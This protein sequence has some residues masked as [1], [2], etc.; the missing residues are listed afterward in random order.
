MQQGGAHIVVR[1]ETPRG[2][3]VEVL[4]TLVNRVSVLETLD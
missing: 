3:A 2:L 4:E 1:D